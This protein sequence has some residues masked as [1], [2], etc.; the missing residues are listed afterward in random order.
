MGTRRV[1]NNCFDYHTSRKPSRAFLKNSQTL[2][3]PLLTL[4]GVS[5]ASAQQSARTEL[6]LTSDDLNMTELIADPEVNLHRVL[7]PANIN[8][9]VRPTTFAVN[10]NPPSC[11]GDVSAWPAAASA[12]FTHAANLWGSL[13][14]SP[15]AIE[16][17]ACWS[18]L[19]PGV[20]G[21]ASA[22]DF[23]RNFSAAP[24][25]DTWYPVALANAY[26]GTD[27]SPGDPE[28]IA[29][30][31]SNLRGWYFG[32]D[33]NPAANQYDF[34]TVVMHEIGHGL[35]FTGLM[36]YGSNRVARWGR[37]SGSPAIYDRF[38]E[39]GSGQSLIDTSIFPNPSRELGLELTSDNL[40]FNGPQVARAN[41]GLPAQIYAPS[42]YQPGS[43][44]AHL[45]REFENTQ[46]SMMTFSLNRGE[47]A[48]DPGPVGL[49]VL[50]DIGW[51]ASRNIA[52]SD[53]DGV[54]NST[55]N[56]PSTPNPDQADAD[57]D[58]IGDVCEPGVRATARF[59]ARV[60]QKVTVRVTKPAVASATAS[61]KAVVTLRASAQAATKPRAEK[62]A[63]SLARKTATTKAKRKARGQA[64][65]LAR[66][67]A[68]RKAKA[69]AN[70]PGD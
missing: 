29:N 27:L 32:T 20:L 41:G 23:F 6:G 55:D 17:D 7:A 5:L 16:I 40:R 39:N 36:E 53:N 44:Y 62:A 60:T 52:D 43:S 24:A 46:N 42:P 64:R 28:I 69:I 4:I 12:A 47:A 51:L 15:Q 25:G 30:F 19:P 66:R 63:R 70:R 9:R 65:R 1:L 31:S 26:S 8:S 50:K 61:A 45:G 2:L 48:H 22:F 67:K 37:G 21:S 10:F 34:V 38:T 49:G 58:N 35:G 59:T 11:S 56:C 18:S 33:A 54:E 57:S 3:I 68:L 13:L 14:T